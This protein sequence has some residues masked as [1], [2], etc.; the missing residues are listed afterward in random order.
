MPSRVGAKR[1]RMPVVQTW[2]AQQLLEFLVY[3]MPRGH[4]FREKRNI[5]TD[6]ESGKYSNAS[7]SICAECAAGSYNDIP[8]L[9][10]CKLCVAGMISASPGALSC[11]D[12]EVGQSSVTNM[13]LM[14]KMC[15]SVNR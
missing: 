10:S 5:C 11:T 14:H 12:C 1:I 2:E 13:C 15:L 3:A 4:N 6:C 8:G 7:A 9:A